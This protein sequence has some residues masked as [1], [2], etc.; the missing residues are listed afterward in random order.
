MTNSN[1]ISNKTQ[2][3]DA[4]LDLDLEGRI[5]ALEPN[6]RQIKA[7]AFSSA[8]PAIRR[9]IDR[10][11]TQRAILKLLSDAGIKVH[12]ARY[13]T[14]IADEAS[15]LIRAGEGAFDSIYIDSSGADAT[16]MADSLAAAR[17]K[18]GAL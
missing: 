7:T 13:K 5:D 9:A 2:M 6:K 12:P 1:L 17:S 4:I 8:Y 10:G 16:P 3:G 11:V 14:M 15:R 18:G